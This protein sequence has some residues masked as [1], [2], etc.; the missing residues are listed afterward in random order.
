M[1][2][3]EFRALIEVWDEQS[4]PWPEDGDPSEAEENNHREEDA[5]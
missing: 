1:S 4:G 3:E 2:R 5:M